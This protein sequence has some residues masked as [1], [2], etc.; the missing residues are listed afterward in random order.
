M[1]LQVASSKKLTV[2]G[3]LQAVG[4]LANPITFDR[5]GSSGYWGGIVFDGSGSS[6]ST[7]KDCII[8]NATRAV[9]TDNSDITIERNEIDTT[10][11]HEPF[12]IS[13][14]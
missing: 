4:T 7:L 6:N 12:L 10:D 3:T 8:K 11:E 5:S 9:R 1:T 2:N 14:T 13:E